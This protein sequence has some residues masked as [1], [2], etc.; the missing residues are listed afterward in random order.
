MKAAAAHLLTRGVIWTGVL[1]NQGR[2]DEAK[3]LQKARQMKHEVLLE[4]MIGEM[5]M[6]IPVRCRA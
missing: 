1:F 5:L 6:T 3:R 4:S 2:D